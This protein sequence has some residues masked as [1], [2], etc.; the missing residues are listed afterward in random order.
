MQPV[1]GHVG[2]RRAP[3]RIAGRAAFGPQRLDVR[4]RKAAQPFAA[5]L[6][7]SLLGGKVRRRAGRPPGRGQLFQKGPLLLAEHPLPKGL[8]AKAFS[9]RSMRTMSTP[10]PAIMAL[11]LLFPFKPILSRPGPVGKAAKPV[12]SACKKASG[13]L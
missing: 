12:F 4:Q 10:T 13:V 6:Q 2:R 8:A 3:K 5:G 1:F 7:K 11:R 9:I